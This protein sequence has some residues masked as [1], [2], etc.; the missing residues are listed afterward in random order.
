[1]SR[2]SVSYEFALLGRASRPPLATSPQSDAYSAHPVNLDPL[3]D[4]R[5][6]GGLADATPI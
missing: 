3:A 4:G 6:H 5:S 2:V 1:M